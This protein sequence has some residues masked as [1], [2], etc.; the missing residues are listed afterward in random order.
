[1]QITCVEATETRQFIA[2]VLTAT[3][4]K[5]TRSAYLLLFGWKSFSFGWC[6]IGLF[7]GRAPL[8]GFLQWQL[9]VYLLY[10]PTTSC[11]FQFLPTN[12]TNPLE[13]FR[14]AQKQIGLGS[15][16]STHGGLRH[17]PMWHNAVA[18]KVYHPLHEKDQ[19]T[20]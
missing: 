13:T 18:I 19:A 4:G 9:L 20:G 7:D 10:N 1:M 6:C 16:I 12:A 11:S 8:G 2:S 17:N 5:S 3:T 15:Q 14:T